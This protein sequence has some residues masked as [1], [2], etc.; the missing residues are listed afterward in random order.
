MNVSFCPPPP[1]H[2]T[3]MHF[4]AGGSQ[5]IEKFSLVVGPIVLTYLIPNQFRTVA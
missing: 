2:E 3:G 4:T 1:P 5:K